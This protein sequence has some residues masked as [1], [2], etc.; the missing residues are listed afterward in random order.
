M[1]TFS[2]FEKHPWA[3]KALIFA[4]TELNVVVHVLSD[5]EMARWSEKAPE[6]ITPWPLCAPVNR[7]LVDAL[8]WCSMGT[9]LTE[10]D[11]RPTRRGELWLSEQLGMAYPKERSSGKENG[12]YLTV[13]V[14]HEIAHTVVGRDEMLCTVYERALAKTIGLPRGLYRNLLEYAP[15]EPSKFERKILLQE[16]VIAREGRKA[17]HA[18]RLA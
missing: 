7:V 2:W 13:V 15:G 16:G 17:P 14:L 11:A 18:V 6:G 5:D 12:T 3:A 8:A 10:D 9:D 4:Q 1:T